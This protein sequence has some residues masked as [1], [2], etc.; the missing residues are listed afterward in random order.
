MATRKGKLRN[1]GPLPVQPIDRWLAPVQRFMHIEA[2]SGI[3]L[4]VCAALALAIAN[5]PYAKEFAS[6]WKMPIVLLFNE[7]TIADTF[8]HLIIND[9]LMTIFFFVIG[10]EV[11]RE[12]VHGELRDPKKALLPIVAALG[13]MVGPALVYLGLQWGEPGQRGWAIPMATDIAFVVGLLALFGN[14][15][16]FSLKIFLLTL[17]IVDDLGAVLVIAFVL[18]EEI[19]FGWLM[20]AG[21]G[22][23]LTYGLNLVGARKVGV[24]VVVG[25][26]I[27]LCFLKAGIHPTVAGV[28][29]GLLTPAKSL[30]GSPAFVE[31]LQQ[32]MSKAKRENVPPESMLPSIER[33]SFAARETVAPVHRLETM[34]HPWVAFLIMPVF[35]LAN[36]GVALDPSAIREPVA[37]A[38]AAGLVLG[39][40]LGILLASGFAVSLGWTR[41]PDGVTWRMM[42]GGAC[43]AGIGFTMALFIN[44]LSFPVSEFPD[45]E[46]A[47]KIGVLAGSL[48]NGLLGSALLASA[49][50]AGRSDETS[51]SDSPHSH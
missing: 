2:T 36:A 38:V 27:W 23:A 25:A 29:L 31:I 47:G 16:P 30:I 41:L 45:K 37:L 13:G 24:Y 46:A 28:L 34:L 43:L 50:S 17:A 42:V 7:F 10:L 44:T 19:A 5:S 40:P 49:G 21:F 1:R 6:F 18:T 32:T 35:A 12:I 9:G 4:M 48:V 39:K 15:V 33:L 8:G 14:R 11:K 22:F 3:L 20:A 51:G 26:F